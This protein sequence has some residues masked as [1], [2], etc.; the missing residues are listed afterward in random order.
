MN[1]LTVLEFE[2]EKYQMFSNENE[3]A[4]DIET[5]GRAAGYTDKRAFKYL[6]QLHPELTSSEFSFLQK[7]DSL[8]GGVLKR[9]E[10]RFF[11]EQ[12][13]YEV[14]F[15][16]ATE[17]SKR[18]RRM[19]RSFITSYRKGELKVPGT[20]EQLKL[21]DNK[22]DEIVEQIKLGAEPLS[23]LEKDTEKVV[24]LL[25][26]LEE[27]F[28]KFERMEKKIQELTEQNDKLQWA[29]NTLMEGIGDDDGE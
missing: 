7:V 17:K 28:K 2:D 27:K 24:D 16:A 11:N 26:K 15:L 29:I 19:V 10:K 23:K 8:E 25:E 12:G 4:M 20:P 18:F 13:I 6:I 21:M 5:L 22:L 1:K 14:L 3:I 9:R